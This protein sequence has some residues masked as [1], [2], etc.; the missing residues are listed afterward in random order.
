MSGKEAAKEEGNDLLQ[1]FLLKQKIRNSKI[2][3]RR[4]FTVSDNQLVYSSPDSSEQLG[5]IHLS[6]ILSV[7]AHEA[8]DTSAKDFCFQ[9]ATSDRV[10]FLQAPSPPE[11]DYW[12]EGLT[13]LLQKQPTNLRRS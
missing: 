12:V 9:I 8:L 7:K 4:F 6:R 11:R 5:N 2:W 10:F 3:Q 13:K 1:G